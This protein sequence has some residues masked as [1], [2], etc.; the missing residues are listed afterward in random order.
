MAS[1]GTSPGWRPGALAQ[2]LC[3]G[4]L[5]QR[6]DRLLGGV[7][8]ALAEVRVA[9]LAL[10]VDQVLGRPVLVAPGVPG[11]VVVVLRDRVAQPAAGDRVAHVAGVL[12]ELE[13]RRVDADDGQPA[14]A[15]ALVPGPQVRQRADA[16]DARV[17]PE[18]DQHD[19][20][21][22]LAQRERRR[23]EPARDARELRRL[24][25]LRQPAR[26]RREARR[27]AQVGQLLLDR[28]RALERA[29]RVDE[30]GRQVVGDRG[31]EAQ[32]GVD[33]D[34]ERGEHHHRAHDALERRAA[35]AAAA[36][37]GRRGRAR[38]GRPPSRP[39]S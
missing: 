9:D 3:A 31:L 16:V 18:V 14:V 6:A 20:P 7:V 26:R 29:G 21:A 35:D 30:H 8:L 25:E 24:A 1:P 38:A 34:G 2:R 33:E 37:A 23:V 12:L 19:L 27:A 39:R 4:L 11:A 17:G 10:G 28:V 32:V 15:V 13:L 22:Q 5:E 36:P